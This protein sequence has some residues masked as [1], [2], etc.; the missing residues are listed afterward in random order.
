MNTK[1]N[2]LI[3]MWPK[4]TLSGLLVAVLSC[5]AAYAQP[6]PRTQTGPAVGERTA[7]GEQPT[8]PGRG[9]SPRGR[10]GG[11]EFGRPAGRS[12]PWGDLPEPDRRQIERFMEE[13]FPR[14]YVEMQRL[15]D[16]DEN[17]YNRR[18]T[19]IVPQMRK[20]MEA[21]RT[22]PQRGTLMIRERQLEFEIQ[23]TIARFRNAKNDEAKRRI[24]EHL[25]DLVGKAFDCRKERRRMEVRELEARLSELQT[26]LS[27]SEKMRPELIRRRAEDML[28]KPALKSEVES[29]DDREISPEEPESDPE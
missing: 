8:P 22:D 24:R 11:P 5:P 21:M 1:E 16:R 7:Q 12:K 27:E 18:M 20:I 19:R 3:T 17:R 4:F 13:H 26:R 2:C 23:Q 14:M 9:F 25:E 29:D 6:A 10:P 15:K 28:D